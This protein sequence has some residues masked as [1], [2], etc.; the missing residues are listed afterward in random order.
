MRVGLVKKK[1]GPVHPRYSRSLNGEAFNSPQQNLD[2]INCFWKLPFV[3]VEFV[4]GNRFAWG[5][6]SCGGWGANNLL[7]LFPFF[8]SRFLWVSLILLPVFPESLSIWIS[9]FLQVFV[10]ALSFRTFSATIAFHVVPRTA[11]SDVVT[12]I[13]I[14]IVMDFCTSPGVM[15]SYLEWG[16]RS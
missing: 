13:N 14:T 8:I 16:C 2:Y 15:H 4:I 7:L 11:V 12:E 9:F 6:V 1:S 5:G 3:R 10:T